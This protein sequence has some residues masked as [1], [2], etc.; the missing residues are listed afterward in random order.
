MTSPSLAIQAALVAQIRALNT[1]ADARVY[2]VIPQNAAY[3]YVMVWPG[4]ETPIDEECFDRTETA[5]QIDVWADSTS[6]IKTK[7]V[8]AAIRA[9]F[10]EKPMTIDGHTVDR[11]RVE[12]I[13]Y[14]DTPP[15]YRARINLTIDTQ[16]VA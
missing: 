3:P 1:A 11:V 6:Y 7:E 13:N 4:V 2:S 16:P 15:T 14:S 9:A 10:H 8:A 5:Q 12:T